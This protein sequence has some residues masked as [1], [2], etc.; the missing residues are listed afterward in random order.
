MT[1]LIC[2]GLL[3]HLALVTGLVT[4]AN[5]EVDKNK[6][7]NPPASDLGADFGQGLAQWQKGDFDSAVASLSKAIEQNPKN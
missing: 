2:S 3:M 7:G 1:R 4:A 5:D 6:D